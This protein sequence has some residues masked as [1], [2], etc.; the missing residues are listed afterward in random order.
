[1]KRLLTVLGVLVTA[2]VVL[3]AVMVWR[4]SN[5]GGGD[6]DAS[7]Q[8]PDP[9]NIDPQIAAEALGQA[10]RFE[11]VTYE[12]GDPKPGEDQAWLDLHAFLKDRYPLIHDV[13]PPELV[14]GHT[15]LFTWQ[16]SDPSLQPIILMAH[17]DV[18]PV[19]PGTESDWEHGPFGGVVTDGYIWGRGAMDD[20][21]SVIALLEAAEALLRVGWR[22]KRTIILLF[23]HDEEVSGSGARAAFELLKSREVDPFM[24]VD[25]GFFVLDD[26]PITGG[27]TGL[28]GVAEKGSVTLQITAHTEG[29]HSSRP[30]L[31]SGA[32]RIARAITALDEHQMPMDL[33]RPPFSDMIKSLADNLPYTTRLALANQWL[34]GDLVKAQMQADASA[35]AMARTTTAPTMMSG[36]IKQNVLPQR[37]NATVNF[38][39][40]PN[41]S[42]E[43]VVEH[44]KDVTRDIPDLSVE[45]AGGIGSEPSPVSATSGPAWDI[46]KAI[47]QVTGDGAPVAPALVIAATDARFASAISKD[48]VYR[49]VPAIYGDE[50]LA[51]FHGTNERLSVDNLGRMIRGYSQLMQ[52]ASP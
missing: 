21:G 19:N 48:A 13:A 15:L 33:S 1:M 52:A 50:D 51:G 9:P 18:V 49:F 35:A 39:I 47:A 7:F 23:G 11:T 40:H 27:P 8:L 45:I 42:I 3:G 24:V 41:D 38:R 20:K 5:W 30:P 12:D 43:K 31:N 29:G 36:S 14:A 2:I 32:V 4:T 10:I 34:L 44:V 16:G 6:T 22:P 26:N 17:Q 25:E 28:I 46:L 37:A